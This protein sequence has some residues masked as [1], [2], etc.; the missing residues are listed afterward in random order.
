MG[1]GSGVE[2]AVDRCM[3]CGAQQVVRFGAAEWAAAELPAEQRAG[4]SAA[5]ERLA[6]GG[7]V[8]A[9]VAAH[10]AP[11]TGPPLVRCVPWTVAHASMLRSPVDA[12]ILALVVVRLAK[13]RPSYGACFGLC[14]DAVHRWLFGAD[15]LYAGC[16]SLRGD[17]YPARIASVRCR[18]AAKPGW[19][20]FDT[21]LRPRGNGVCY[22]HT[23]ETH[24]LPL[25]MTNSAL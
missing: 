25:L 8:S 3:I 23:S 11:S 24:S 20:P 14:V 9:L 10:C 13:G 12:A 17:L 19:S 2:G 4:V 5:A 1:S 22:Q 21:T 6:V 7:A 15:V 18:D 16:F